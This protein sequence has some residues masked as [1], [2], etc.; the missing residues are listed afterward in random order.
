MSARRR[1][2]GQ[3]TSDRQVNDSL[4]GNAAAYPGT[5]NSKHGDAAALALH[6]ASASTWSDAISS[7]AASSS[8]SMNENIGGSLGLATEVAD[9]GPPPP[10][11]SPHERES[12]IDSTN[13]EPETMR[14]HLVE[15]GVTASNHLDHEVEES[16]SD[17]NLDTPLLSESGEKSPEGWYPWMLVNN[18]A[19]TRR[20]PR[21]R[22]YSAV[23]LMLLLVI[24]CV[25]G[26][27]H[28]WYSLEG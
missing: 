11:S 20:P 27:S 28:V 14:Q 24:G 18:T 1:N 12:T 9:L 23:G 7:S 19:S 15:H 21:W 25:L 16:A 5:N 10:Y 2:N 4:T 6:L 3:A 13:A 17:D 22:L 8:E 26:F